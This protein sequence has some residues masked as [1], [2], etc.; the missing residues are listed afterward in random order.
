MTDAP[1]VVEMYPRWCRLR[2]GEAE[3]IWGMRDGKKVATG[4]KTRP[5]DFLQ[6]AK[7]GPDGLTYIVY[8]PLQKLLQDYTRNKQPLYCPVRAM[9]DEVWPHFRMT[10]S[11]RGKAAGKGH[12]VPMCERV[13]TEADIGPCVRRHEVRQGTAMCMRPDSN[14]PKR[15]IAEERNCL[16]AG[17][18]DWERPPGEMTNENLR[19]TFGY[20]LRFYLPFLEAEMYPQPAF[21]H[22]SSWRS[23]KYFCTSLRQIR[24]KAGL[25]EGLGLHI[26]LFTEM[27]AQYG[28]MRCNIIFPGNEMQ[29]KLAAAVVRQERAQIAEGDEVASLPMPEAPLA[30]MDGLAS[31][32]AEQR[33]RA[34]EF[35]GDDDMGAIDEDAAPTVPEDEIE[36]EAEEVAPDEPPTS[37]PPEEGGI[38][39]TELRTYATKHGVAKDALQHIV[40]T[41]DQSHP[42]AGAARNEFI[43]EQLTAWVE[44]RDAGDGEQK[45][46]FEDE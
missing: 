15:L 43:M 35:G 21:Y 4:K 24:K 16:V 41:A 29:L 7:P 46:L 28:Q 45:D 34:I 12:P 26:V 31:D 3:V 32:P 9:S 19:C 37:V 13:L 44:R 33:R 2:H 38:T 25:L 1:D 18:P 30:L 39:E 5:L 11:A 10:F 8:P 22:S 6:L 23:G 17:C 14:N 20:D 42:T 40:S 27:G 36:A